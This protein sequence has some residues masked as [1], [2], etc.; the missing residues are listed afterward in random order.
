MLSAGLAVA[1]G[2]GATVMDSGGCL[3]CA[4]CGVISGTAGDALVAGRVDVGEGVFDGCG[5]M[6]T[7]DG[8]GITPPLHPA[9][10]AMNSRLAASIPIALIIRYSTEGRLSRVRYP[11]ICPLRAYNPNISL[12]YI[13]WLGVAR[14][15]YDVNR[16]RG[17]HPPACTCVQCTERRTRRNRR[18]GGGRRPGGGGGGS[19]GGRRFGCLPNL[20]VLAVVAAVIVAATVVL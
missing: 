14:M 5:R 20:L 6:S 18:G 16:L 7:G 15:S 2:S 17:T 9:I 4:G 13:R 8:S 12:Q 11:V 3:A 19:S 1:A 10:I